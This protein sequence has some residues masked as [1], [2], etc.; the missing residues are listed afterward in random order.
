MKDQL[1]KDWPSY[2]YQAAVNADGVPSEE[3]VDR[4]RREAQRTE[5]PGNDLLERAREL[6]VQF[7]GATD[8]K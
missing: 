2:A 8:E 1:P 7:R 5:R 3:I 6:A 4:Q